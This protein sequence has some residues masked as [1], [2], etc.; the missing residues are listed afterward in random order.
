MQIEIVVPDSE[1][2]ESVTVV[3]W[4]HDEGAEVMKGANLL[5]VATEKATFNISTPVSGVLLKRNFQEGENVEVGS[6]VAII[7]KSE[8][9]K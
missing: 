2:V 5:E 8:V 4:H 7:E 1:G 3:Y 6:V 9:M